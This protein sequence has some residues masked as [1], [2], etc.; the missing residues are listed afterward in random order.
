MLVCRQPGCC[1]CYILDGHMKCRRLVCENANARLFDM[2]I[3]GKAV[4][5]CTGTPLP[6]SR[7]CRK[8]KAASAQRDASGDGPA[9]RPDGNVSRTEVSLGEARDAHRGD[10]GDVDDAEAK[11]SPGEED[12]YLVERARA[13]DTT[14]RETRVGQMMWP[15][16]MAE[17]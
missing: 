15:V 12:V 6:G 3:H 10:A 13:R 9:P 17:L 4:L 7:F 5:G 11:L 8:C 16:A 1:D 2:G 14:I